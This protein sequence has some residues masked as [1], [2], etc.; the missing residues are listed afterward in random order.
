MGRMAANVFAVS[1]IF[2]AGICTHVLYQR[3]NPPTAEL[4]ETPSVAARA[5]TPGEPQSY[6]VN[7]VPLLATTAEAEQSPELA[8]FLARDVEKIRRLTG[9]QARV[10]GRIF[11]VGHSAKSNTY[12]LNFG[13]SREALSAVIF[14]SAVDLFD[15]AKTAP[16]S[17]ENKEVEITGQVKDHPQYG[18]EIIIENPK[19]IKIIN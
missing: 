12:F 8:E 19:Q 18:L 9:K 6:L 1:A 15:K 4:P 3:W 14:S 5:L 2:G 16:K 13:P 10:R 7:Y 17:F 11:R